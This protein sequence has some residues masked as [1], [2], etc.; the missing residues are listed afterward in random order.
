M[1]STVLTDCRPDMEI[2]RKEIFGPVA[3]IVVVDSAEEAVHHANDTEYGLTSSL[4]TRPQQGAEGDVQPSVRRDLHQSEN[5]KNCVGFH[6]ADL[7][8]V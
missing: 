4:Y 1:N 5:G 2:V 3:P 8:E 6:A 7:K